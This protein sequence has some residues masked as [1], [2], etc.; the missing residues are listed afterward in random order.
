M[1]MINDEI[2]TVLLEYLFPG[3]H[4]HTPNPDTMAN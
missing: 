1:S 4:T 2:E 3:Q